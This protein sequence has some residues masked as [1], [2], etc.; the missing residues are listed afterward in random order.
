MWNA[1][2]QESFSFLGLGLAI[3]K[4]DTDLASF[5]PW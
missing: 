4:I 1:V 5:G 2:E 3:I